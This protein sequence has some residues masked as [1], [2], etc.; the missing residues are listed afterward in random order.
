MNDLEEFFNSIGIVNG[1]PTAHSEEVTQAEELNHTE[2][3]AQASNNLSEDDFNNI[4]SDMGFQE[5]S[6]EEIHDGSDDAGVIADDEVYDDNI[7]GERDLDAEE[8]AEWENR[9]ESGE[10]QE[11]HFHMP[12][13]STVDVPII[14]NVATDLANANTDEEVTQVVANHSEEFLIP[15][16]SPTLLQNDSTSRFSGTEWYNEIKRQRIILA[17]CGG[18]GSWTALQLAR[19]SPEA[20]FL[21]DDDVVEIANMSGQLYGIQD[22]GIP[23]VDAIARIIN[24]YTTA[25]NIYALNQRFTPETEAGNIMICGFDNMQARRTFFDA[26]QKHV[27]SLPKEEWYKCL[28]LDGIIKCLSDNL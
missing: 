1:E 11:V 16:N 4:L 20:L 22:I 14:Y 21:Y 25:Q 8:D 17:G 27:F 23:K 26:W 15:P 19:M 28:Y 9:I 3:P 12:N 7:G 10:L 13:G 5:S 6:E 18:I 24:S 2:E